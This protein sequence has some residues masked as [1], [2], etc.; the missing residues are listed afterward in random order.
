MSDIHHVEFLVFHVDPL[1]RRLVETE[2]KEGREEFIQVYENCVSRVKTFSY[3]TVGLKA[4]TDFFLWRTSSSLD[5]L[6]ET[7][8]QLLCTGL[9]KYLDI[10]NSFIGMVRSSIYVKKQEP[11]EQALFSVDRQRYLIF[12]P[13]VKTT[14]WYLL[15]KEVRQGMMNQHIRIGHDYPGVRQVLVYSFGLDDQD[16]VVAYE[17]DDLKEYQDLVMSLREVEVRRFTL[18]DTPIFTGIHRPLDEVLDL[19]G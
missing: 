11:Q 7:T 5:D 8:S 2:R 18:R 19:L 10:V 16:F 12:Y 3:S 9:G 1:W 14:D 4:G 6:Q 17:T 13:F 15:S